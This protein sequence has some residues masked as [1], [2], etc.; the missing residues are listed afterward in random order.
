MP[1]THYLDN[2]FLNL[3]LRGIQFIPPPASYLG[4]YTVMPTVLGD[5]SEVV[6]GGYLRPLVF[7]GEPVAGQ[8]R[9][10]ADVL[11]PV[12]S[13]PWGIVV[14]FA[15]LDAEL[16]G[17]MLYFGELVPKMVDVV[18]QVRFPAGALVCVET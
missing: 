4:L 17:N 2:S 13:M 11:F 12:A 16:D 6:G 9:N 1:K 18:D 7:F 10:V 14:A 5:G 3:A 8:T 15:L